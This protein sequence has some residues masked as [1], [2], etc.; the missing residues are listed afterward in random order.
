[1]GR[2]KPQA[3]MHSHTLPSLR[4]FDHIR[5]KNPAWLHQH[6]YIAIRGTRAHP[7]P[8]PPLIGVLK[9]G[10]GEYDKDWYIY[11]MHFT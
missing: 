11:A 6:N 5:L 7:A 10:G 3:C 8:P 2:G 4:R 1:M 9:K